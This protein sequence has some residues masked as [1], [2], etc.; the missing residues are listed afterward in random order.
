MDTHTLK[1]KPHTHTHTEAHTQG[2][3]RAT[4]ATGNE[5]YT[6]SITINCLALTHVLKTSKCMN[7]CV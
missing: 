6:L 4:T 1:L 7:T 3:A 2:D 5:L